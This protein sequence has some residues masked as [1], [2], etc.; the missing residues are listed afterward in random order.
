MGRKTVLYILVALVFIEAILILLVTD[1]QK[2]G[3]AYFSS[4]SSSLFSNVSLILIAVFI[5]TLISLLVSTRFINLPKKE[6]LEHETEISY[7]Y[8][9]ESLQEKK[10]KKQIIK[11]LEANGF[12]RKEIYDFLKEWEHRE[13][14]TPR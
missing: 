4:Y 5:A 1:L 13:E 6:E 12:S 9:E 14:K 10:P 11:D 2:S 3:K 8:A 7:E